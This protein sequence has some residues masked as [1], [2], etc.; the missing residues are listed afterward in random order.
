MNRIADLRLHPVISEE[1]DIKK[2]VLFDT[3]NKGE[4][5]DDYHMYARFALFDPLYTEGDEMWLEHAGNSNTYFAPVQMQ[6]SIKPQRWY[7]GKYGEPVNIWYCDLLLHYNKSICTQFGQF[8]EGTNIYFDYK[9]I[10]KDGACFRIIE[11]HMPYRKFYILN[12]DAYTGVVN[13]ETRFTAP[14]ECDKMIKVDSEV[15]WQIADQV[16]I[17]DDNI[18][19]ADGSFLHKDLQVIELKEDEKS[20]NILLGPYY[21]SM[22]HACCQLAKMYHVTAILNIQTEFEIKSRQQEENISRI[23]QNIGEYVHCEVSDT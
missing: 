19:K 11:E 10:K 20:L 18:F 23:G 14:S 21:H 8:E 16:S 22:G 2:I 1:N 3:W 17:V 4:N 7:Q 5:Q 6:R 13:S 9:Y 15:L 12:P